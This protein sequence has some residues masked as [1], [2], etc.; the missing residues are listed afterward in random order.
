MDSNLGKR[1]DLNAD[2]LIGYQTSYLHFLLF[3]FINIFIIILIGCIYFETPCIYVYISLSFLRVTH[4]NDRYKPSKASAS[5]LKRLSFDTHETNDRTFIKNNRD[6]FVCFYF[7]TQKKNISGHYAR[8]TL[9]SCGY[10][11]STC[12]TY[13]TIFIG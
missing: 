5:T 11:M 4:T 9:K 7:W 8:R 13:I 2:F 6:F 12:C 3:G 1:Q 10:F